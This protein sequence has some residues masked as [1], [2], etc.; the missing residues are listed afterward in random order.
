MDKDPAH[1]AEAKQREQARPST[2][3]LGH[4]DPE[5]TYSADKPFFAQMSDARWAPRGRAA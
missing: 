1:V 5:G 4:R 3:E 2:A